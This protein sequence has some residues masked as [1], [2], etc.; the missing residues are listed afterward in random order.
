MVGGPAMMPTDRIGSGYGNGYWAK[1]E[2]EK[3]ETALRM[4]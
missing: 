1:D 2:K 4:V 3:Y